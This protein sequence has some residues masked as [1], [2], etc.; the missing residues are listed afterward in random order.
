[1]NFAGLRYLPII[2]ITLLLFSCKG[3]V[4]DTTKDDPIF[5]HPPLKAISEKIADNPTKASL[6]YQRGVM[7]HKMQK[8]TLALDDFNKAVKLDSTKA[9]YFSAIGD[10]MFEH[11]DL[12]GSVGWLAK[13]IKLNPNDPKAHLKL[14]KMQLFLKEYKGAFAEINTVLRQDAMNPEGYFLK[15]VIYKNLLDT[16]RA[17]SSFLTALQ[18]MP[19]Y[20]DPIMQLGL[21]YSY[22]KN[23]VALKY[24]DNAYKL[25]P[26]DVSPI[27]A[28][29]MYY[30]EQGKYEEA[31]A[32]YKECILKDIA[33]ADAYF[34][35]GWILMQQDSLEKAKRQYDLATKQD[36]TNAAAYYNR[37][38]CS[39]MMGDKQGAAADYKQALTF[40]EKYKE[41][42][43]GLKRLEH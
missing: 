8:D 16:T 30:Q 40:D 43:E 3:K 1:M 10:L 32:F 41:A 36:P 5:K 23:P 18:V 21:L 24:F 6:Y 22:K 14:A 7:L 15:G 26:K 20:K 2:V 13:A 38:L 19:D 11:K 4:Q 29:G 35:S 33:Y 39:E 31:K 28:K 37:G 12:E 17:I 42:K 27:Y 9:E 34:S 25:D